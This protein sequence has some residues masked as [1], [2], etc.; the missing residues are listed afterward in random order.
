M[1]STGFEAF[2]LGM[3]GFLIPFAFVFQPSLLLQGD[4]LAILK[5]TGLTALGI[6]C[7]AASLIGCIWQPLNWLHRLSFIGAAVLLVFPSIGL[8]LVGVG[9]AIA[10]FLWARWEKRPL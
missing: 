1:M 10:L 5:G 9:L 8:E 3:A 4:L 6:A 7:L 2:K